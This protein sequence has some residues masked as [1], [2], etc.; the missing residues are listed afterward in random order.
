M[1]AARNE[2]TVLN[3]LLAAMSFPVCNKQFP[4]PTAGNSPVEVSYFN[5]FA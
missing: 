2:Q 1:S 3:S 4:V 5:G